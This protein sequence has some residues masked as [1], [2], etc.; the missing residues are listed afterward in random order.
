MHSPRPKVKAGKALPEEP[1]VDGEGAPGRCS[2]E[3]VFSFPV[4]QDP[5]RQAVQ[6]SKLGP[7]L[8]SNFSEPYLIY[9]GLEVVVQ[10]GS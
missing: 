9:V 2:V 8:I 4:H 10:G 6:K 7:A 1:E 3:Q 5:L